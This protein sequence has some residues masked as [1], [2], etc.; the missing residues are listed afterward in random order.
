[1]GQVLQAT[2]GQIVRNSVRMIRWRDIQHEGTRKMKMQ[3]AVAAALIGLSTH[4]AFAWSEGGDTWSSV[5]PKAYSGSAPVM[6]VSTIGSLSQLQSE[7]TSGK[8]MPA[9]GDASDRIVELSPST[10]WVSVAYGEKV[11]FNTVGANGTQRSFA[12][13]FEV[14]PVR[15]FVDLDDVAPADFPARSVRVFVAEAPEY[16]GG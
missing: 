11:T 5:A 4:A 3:H 10:R 1:M 9:T 13:Q 15:S 16:R 8:G 6:T 14:S 7:R 12:W 2:F